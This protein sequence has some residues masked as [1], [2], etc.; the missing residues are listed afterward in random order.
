[1]ITCAVV[2]VL[3]VFLSTDELDSAEFS[4]VDYINSQFRTEQV[5]MLYAC[6]LSQGVVTTNSLVEP[7]TTGIKTKSSDQEENLH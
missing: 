6:N 5:R 3:Q 1:M 4:L 7:S 2:R